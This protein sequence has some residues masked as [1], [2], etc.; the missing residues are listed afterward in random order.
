MNKA[1]KKFAA[2]AS[3]IILAIGFLI[4]S[5]AISS[6]SYYRTVSEV[7]AM[8]EQA[9][10]INLRLEGKALPGSIQRDPANLNLSF[11]LVDKSNQSLAVD[12]H[13]IVPDNFK[14]D[15]PV[16]VEGMLN[17]DGKLVAVKLLTQCETRYDAAGKIKTTM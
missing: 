16:V 5:A 1:Q 2:G 8:G 17:P 6:G 3:V 4:Y 14:D 9:K 15:A 7:A 10:G 11:K 12:Y 13:G